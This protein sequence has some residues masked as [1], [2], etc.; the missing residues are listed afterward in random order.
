MSD[1]VVD[2]K[3]IDQQSFWNSEH[4]Y[5]YTKNTI[6]VSGIFKGNISSNYIEVITR[7]GVVGM[8]ALVV[9]PALNLEMNDIG[10]FLLKGSNI[11][12]TIQ[13]VSNEVYAPVASIQSFIKYNLMENVA[14]G[15][16]ETYSGISSN[17]ANEVQKITETEYKQIKKNTLDL[18]IKP[19]AAP[20]VNGLD[21]DTVEAGIGN[22]LTITGSN[23]GVIKGNGYV[24][25]LDPNFG[26][27]RYYP[28]YYPTS[29]KSWSNSKIE[30]YIPPRAGTG[31]I[32]VVN[33]SSE[34]GTSNQTIYVKYAHSNAVYKGGSG[35]DSGFFQ[36]RL[37][38]LSGN[39]GYRWQFTDNFSQKTTAVNAFYRALE[40]W[41]CGTGMNWDVGNNTSASG[42]AKDNVNIVQ[43]TVLDAGVLGVCS[44]WYNGCISGG[45]VF[46]YVSELDISFDSTR[47]WYFG[48]VKPG[49][50]QYDFETVATHELGHGHQLTH[51]IDKTKIMHYSLTNGD[52]NT[53]LHEHDIEGGGY[54]RD[55]SMA[56]AV[57]GNSKFVPI[58][59]QNC[60]ITKPK[61]D[62]TINIVSPCPGTNVRFTDASEGKVNTYAWSF[63]SGA[64]TA[65]ATTVG[66]HTL[67]YDSKG[68]RTIKLIVTNDFGSDTASKTI[69]VQPGTPEI[70]VIATTD[71]ACLGQNFYYVGKVED[72]S[73]YLWTLGSGGTVVGGSTDTVL[74]INWNQTGSHLISVVAKNSCGTSAAATRNVDVIEPA[75]SDFSWSNSGLTVSFV[76]LSTNYNSTK[77]FY[78]NGDSSMLGNN[79]Y[80]YAKRGKFTVSLNASNVCSDSTIKK[81]IEIDFGASIANGQLDKFQI[82]PNPVSGYF[83]LKSEARILEIE[84]FDELGKK[85]FKCEEYQNQSIETKSWNAGIYVLRIISEEGIHNLKLVVE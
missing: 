13:S 46:Y 61:A 20:V 9:E 2:G 19:L 37:I 31:K 77:W 78:G 74:R 38:N 57:C 3:V 40:T 14:Y 8:D 42:V 56:N 83:L 49:V 7:G 58:N 39:G 24:E 69:T 11:K 63:G 36:T 45:N 33:N 64:S 66:P 50:S 16:F 28:L 60:N 32:R 44:S 76:N 30:V 12:P 70:P 29:Y 84:V 26:D 85:V 22:L 59:Y 54:V 10:L 43:F 23:F 6:E 71:T 65:S 17:L 41:R 47:N 48:D 52:R 68:E 55:Q 80:K 62:F 75:V 4:T 18:I 34:T 15:Y 79:D 5:I 81:E 72:A 21:K 35:V 27:G 53:T 51:V 1:L 67:N 25:F 82:V 73:S